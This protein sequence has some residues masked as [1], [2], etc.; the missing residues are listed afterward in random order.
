MIK[1]HMDYESE[2]K[3][4][5]KREQEKTHYFTWFDTDVYVQKGAT[6]LFFFNNID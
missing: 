3:I 4:N 1:A 6:M 2:R 5:Q